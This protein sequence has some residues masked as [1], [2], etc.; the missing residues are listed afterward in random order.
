VRRLICALA[1]AAVA[2]GSSGDDAPDA[3]SASSDASAASDAAP[4]QVRVAT[5]N[6]RCL[7][8]DWDA[9]LPLLSAELAAVDPDVVAFQEACHADDG[10]DNLDELLAALSVATGRTYDV[11]RAA[12]HRSW[13]TYDEG[14]ALASH[15]AMSDTSE[16][17][18]P[19][20]VFARKAVVARVDTALGSV[21][22]A[23]THLSFGDQAATRR[24]QLG[25]IRDE[26][27]AL[28]PVVIMGDMNAA[29]TEPAIQDALAAGYADTW[30][31]VN[32]SDAGYTFPAMSPDVRI[33][34]VLVRGVAPASAT[35]FMDVEADG[36]M[37]SDH[38]G[39][40]AVVAA[41]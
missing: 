15:L 2:C 4:A 35:V 32:P 37:P 26:L 17:T 12:T 21:W 14:I 24:A 40:S 31:E 11:T 8:D 25:A 41:N 28:S 39:V 1:T 18:L 27:A 34:H 22:V 6:L 33:D 13:D 19:V 16:V 3:G 10:V 38:L 23:A 9:R 20:G 30:A 5:V 29:P 7:L 36:V